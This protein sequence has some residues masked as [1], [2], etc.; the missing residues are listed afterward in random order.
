MQQQL[1]P[2]PGQGHAVSA[3]VRAVA[4]KIGENAANIEVID[5]KWVDK[6]QEAVIIELRITR[7]RFQKRATYEM[8]GLHPE[9][10]EQRRAMD[11]VLDLGRG[12]LKPVEKLHVFDKIENRARGGI[13][14]LGADTSWG[15][16]VTVANYLQA[17]ELL[18]Q[19]E[20][21]YMAA[22][23]A[24]CTEEAW[25][26]DRK[27]VWDDYYLIGIN[28]WQKLREANARAQVAGRAPVARIGEDPREFAAAFADDFLSRLPTR[29]DARASFTFEAKLKFVPMLSMMA[30]DHAAAKQL[31]VEHEAASEEARQLA[32]ARAEMRLDLERSAGKARNEMVVQLFDE[33]AADIHSRVLNMTLDVLA[34]LK[35][36]DGI[37]PPSN[38]RQLRDIVSAV[39][40][41]N[42]MDDE[43]LNRQCETIR[44]MLAARPNKERD[45]IGYEQV[46]QK[47]G[48]ETQLALLQMGRRPARD[49]RDL[50][51]PTTIPEL[52]TMLEGRQPRRVRVQIR[53]SAPIVDSGA[54]TP[55]LP[56]RPERG[57]RAE[58]QAVTA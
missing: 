33:V 18:A 43:Q 28:N 4:D 21:E 54:A 22:A 36:N 25:E 29:E 41:L 31:L 51:V 26:A 38:V 56:R 37:L 17:K 40:G 9:S 44:L 5:P 57:A 53:P 49:G 19:C 46:M 7:N 24:L 10:P 52:T 35:K 11:R 55:E 6:L 12:Y 34:A 58:Q 15:R 1:E 45:G 3:A 16:L 8:L 13:E 20:T 48:A 27:A 47:I 50:G 2:L 42:F 30:E 14:N 39:K 32:R 23:D